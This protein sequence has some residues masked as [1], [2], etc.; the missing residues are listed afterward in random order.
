MP[1]AGEVG[2]E[3]CDVFFTHVSWGALVMEENKSLDPP[4]IGL[5]GFDAIMPRTNCQVR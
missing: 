5:F 2:Q 1:V 3:M 4:D